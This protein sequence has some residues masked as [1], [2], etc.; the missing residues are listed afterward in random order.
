MV[1]YCLVTI[2]ALDKKETSAGTPLCCLAQGD[3]VR[4]TDFSATRLDADF[5]HRDAGD[6]QR[7]KAELSCSFIEDRLVLI[8]IKV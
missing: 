7:R 8:Q 1:N 4:V 3:W 6:R 2:C 5:A